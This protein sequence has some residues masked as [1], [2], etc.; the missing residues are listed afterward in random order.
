L[1]LCGEFIHFGRI[2]PASLAAHCSRGWPRQASRPL[3][4]LTFTLRSATMD[5]ISECRDAQDVRERPYHIPYGSSL[6]RIPVPAMYLHGPGQS[7]D[8]FPVSPSPLRL[9]AHAHPCARDVPTWPW[10]VSRPVPG[11]TFSLQA[12]RSRASLRPRC[13]YIPV[14]KNGQTLRL[15]VDYSYQRLTVAD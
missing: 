12:H 9:I 6:T 11:L 7:L 8:R 5:R 1:R 2:L 13:T 4:G 15:P 10:P 3:C 14:G